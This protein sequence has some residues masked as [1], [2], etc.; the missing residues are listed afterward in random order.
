MESPTQQVDINRS[1]AELEVQPISEIQLIDTDNNAENPKPEIS[2]TKV[3]DPPPMKRKYVD[4]TK[5]P[6]LY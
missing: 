5:Y 6:H 3:H 4:I 1:K 2:N